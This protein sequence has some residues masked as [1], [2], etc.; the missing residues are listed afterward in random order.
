MKRNIRFTAEYTAPPFFDIAPESM[1]HLEVLELGL[2]PELTGKIIVWDES[3]QKTFCKDY[4]PDSGFH[5][6]SRVEEHNHE[7]SHLCEMIRKELGDSIQ[8]EYLP[9]KE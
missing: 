5:D 6:Q 7:G 8:L 1:G 2:S 9:L 4:P 3:F